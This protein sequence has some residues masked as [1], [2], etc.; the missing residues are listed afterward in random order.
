MHTF[1]FIRPEFLYHVFVLHTKKT[2]RQFCIIKSSYLSLHN[3][4]I[5]ALFLL[6]F[7]VKPAGLAYLCI[8]KFYV[9]SGDYN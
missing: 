8:T 3:A 6:T 5:K 1:F 9:P 2:L 4:I 7:Y